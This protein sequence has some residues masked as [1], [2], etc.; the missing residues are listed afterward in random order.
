MSA[1]PWMRC[2]LAHWRRELDAEVA[3]QLYLGRNL[4]CSQDSTALSCSI[5]NGHEYSFP[6]GALQL[7][8]VFTLILTFWGFMLG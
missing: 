5:N 2:V 7:F 6:L 1:N 4:L 8:P 3:E